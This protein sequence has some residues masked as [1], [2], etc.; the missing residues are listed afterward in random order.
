MKSNPRVLVAVP[1]YG[2]PQF[3]PRIIANFDRLQYDN[4]KLVIINDDFRTKYAFNPDSFSHTWKNINIVN[5]EK[6]I[7]LRISE[8]RNLFLDWDWDIIFFLD[9]DDLFLPDRLINHLKVY[10]ENPN[11]DVVK[12]KR[13]F[14][15][16]AGELDLAGGL[17][18]MNFSITREGVE[19]AGRFNGEIIGSGEDSDWWDKIHNSCNVHY[20][21]DFNS[22]DFIYWFSGSNYH[23]SNSLS[24]GTQKEVD[25]L[26]RFVGEYL[27]D[28]NHQKHINLFPDYKSYDSV[29]KLCNKIKKAVA[30]DATAT[31]LKYDWLDNSDCAGIIQKSDKPKKTDLLQMVEVNIKDQNFGGEPSSC[32]RGTNKFIKWN[33]DNKQVSDSCF[34][35]DYCLED[36]HKM[37]DVNKK[38]AWLL[39][40]RAINE[41]MYE[42]IEKNNRLFDFVL[43]FD[44]Y[45]LSK[46]Q[47]YLQ[48]PHGR[49]WI[50]NYKEI[51]KENKVSVIASGKDY[52]EGHQ[53]RHK[54]IAKFRKDIHVYGYGYTPVEHKEESLSKYMYSITIENCK[55]EGYWTEKIVDCFA[56]KTIPI[57]WGDDAVNDFFDSDGIIYF[58]NEEELGNILYDL[59]ENGK[60]IYSSKA[61]A[62]EHNFSTVEEYRIPED[63][64]YCQYPF[65]FK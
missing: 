10:S 34:M 8:K 55:Q 32:H 1:T 23:A 35:T 36:V 9:D 27:V 57:F 62:I 65:L 64:M 33:F 3:L 56:T 43:T 19:K 12:N 2:R 14:I 51:D 31:S 47:N 63:W 61:D 53:L 25:G 24:K 59:K 21:D 52:T 5:L 13:F 29:T 4:K 60:E 58:N 28:N 49:C 11:I 37:P 20:F 6:E 16:Y 48:Y 44:E 22:A 54:V 46:G 40:P 42:W 39:E 15:T 7:P 45:L 30:K 26:T 50:N 38:I 18:T 41:H 17:C